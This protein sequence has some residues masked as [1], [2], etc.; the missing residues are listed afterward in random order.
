MNQGRLRP[1]GKPAAASWISKAPH[2]RGPQIA[3]S[4]SFNTSKRL[5]PGGPRRNEAPI[6][7]PGGGRPARLPLQCKSPSTACRLPS[8]PLRGASHL[9]A[10]LPPP[11]L[12]A[13]LHFFPPRG[14]LRLHGNGG[15]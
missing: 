10:P 8:L 12:P 15:P 9:P 2:P 4:I 6:D 13:R 1:G 11:P 3:I 7:R 14:E 5:F